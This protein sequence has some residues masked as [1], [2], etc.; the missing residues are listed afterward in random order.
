MF[1]VFIAQAAQ[2]SLPV[3]RM[4][5][6]ATATI[7][8]FYYMNLFLK[9]VTIVATQLNPVLGETL[10]GSYADGTQVC[11]EQISHHPPMSY[12]LVVGPQES[13]RYYGHYHYEAKAGLNSMTLT[14]RGRRVLRFADGH[15]IASN[16]SKDT[17][18]G[19]FLGTMRSEVVGDIEFVDQQNDIRCL[20]Q[21]GKVKNKYAASDLDPQTTSR[22]GSRRT[23]SRSPSS[24]APTW[25][26]S[27]STTSGT[28]TAGSWP[29]FAS[30]SA[31]SPC[32]PT[33]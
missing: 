19:V 28:G 15:S 27:T 21:F 18:S 25:A 32:T 2:A 26:S 29:P 8:S 17:F 5:L 9:P 13:Y 12:M 1:P 22:A 11:L 3:E 7:S 31:R 33:S 10:Q 14:N 6:F 24:T 20:V 4:K 16:F 30:T 23:A